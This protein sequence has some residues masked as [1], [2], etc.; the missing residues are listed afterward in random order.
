MPD[1]KVDWKNAMATT[2]AL[3]YVPLRFLNFKTYG[4]TQTAKNRFQYA[5]KNA[6]NAWHA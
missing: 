5:K 3:T 4:N 6:Y 2:Y 1:V